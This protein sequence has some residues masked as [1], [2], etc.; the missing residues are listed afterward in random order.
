MLVPVPGRG[1]PSEGRGTEAPTPQG[2]RGR[3]C[4][5]RPLPFLFQKRVL[6]LTHDYFFTD[7]SDTPFR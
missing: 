1:G 5:A 6:F 7:I 3:R 4:M 2:H